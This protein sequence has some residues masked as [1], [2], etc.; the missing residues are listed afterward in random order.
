MNVAELINILKLVDP[1]SEVHLRVSG[2]W[3]GIGIDNAGFNIIEFTGEDIRIEQT[4]DFIV[5]IYSELN[6]I[7]HKED[8]NKLQDF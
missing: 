2:K 5:T 4:D 3:D 1:K 7:E 6:R 8:E